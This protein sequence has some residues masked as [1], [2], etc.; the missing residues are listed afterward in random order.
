MTAVPRAARTPATALSST[1]WTQNLEAQ[2]IQIGLVLLLPNPVAHEMPL[3]LAVAR[4]RH[5]AAQY[6][7]DGKSCTRA[8]DFVALG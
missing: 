5:C 2:A 7:S 1:N 4:G 3:R 8:R 6:G